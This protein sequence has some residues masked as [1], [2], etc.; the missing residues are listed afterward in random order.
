MTDEDDDDDRYDGGDDDNND[1]VDE[2]AK[3]EALVQLLCVFGEMEHLV[4][5]LLNL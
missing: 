3:G 4:H 1:D 2:P 5:N